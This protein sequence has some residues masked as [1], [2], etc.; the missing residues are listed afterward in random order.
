MRILRS[1]ILVLCLTST[2]SEAQI[3]APAKSFVSVCDL[4]KS[5]SSFNGKIMAVRGIYT[6]GGHGLMLKGDGCLAPLVTK[7]REWPSLI[8]I[9]LSTEEY[10]RRGLTMEGYN[11]AEVQISNARAI[12][13]DRN[14]DAIVTYRGLFETYTTLNA[15]IGQPADDKPMEP[16]FGPAAAPGQLFVYS[17][18]DI[19]IGREPAP[20]P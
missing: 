13:G 9:S 7:G 3:E 1:T 17:V 10:L 5:P 14:Q 18:E 11:V 6:V 2:D 8:H 16:G 15:E 4:L 20:K 19:V 12:S